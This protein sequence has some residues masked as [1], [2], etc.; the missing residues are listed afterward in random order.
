[1]RRRTHL[2]AAFAVLAVTAA[3]CG[4]SDDGGVVDGSDAD[5]ATTVSVTGTDALEFDP[6]SLTAAAGTVTVELTAEDEVDHT[7][8]I[9]EVGDTEVVAAAPGETA[10]GDI[11]LEAGSYTYYCNV[12]GHREA[13][14]EGELTVS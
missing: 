7:F 13:G 12:A 1:M 9:E 14:M 3:A 4:S 2:A 5:G 8:V 6:G 10:T 11:E